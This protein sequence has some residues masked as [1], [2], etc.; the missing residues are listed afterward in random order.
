MSTDNAA[1]NAAAKAKSDTAFLG[2]P[3]GL[4]W[5]S[6]SEFW[7][8]FSYYGMQS[9]LVLYLLN[10]LLKPG[11]IEQVWGFEAFHRMLQWLGRAI[12]WLFGNQTEMAV[13]SMTSQLYA[14][15]V[16]VTPLLGGVLADR[17]L[18]R[19]R[20]VAIGTLMMLFGT[21]LLALNQ[22]FLIG[23]A[24][25][26]AGVGC[27]K[28]NI[29]SQV[30]DLYRIDDKRRA[31]GFQ[32]YFMGI[33]LAVITAPLICGTLGQKVDWHLGFVASGVGMAL[34]LA[35]YLFGRR[36]FPPE[37]IRQTGKAEKAP[38][39]TLRDWGVVILLVA[40]LPFLALSIIG[41]QEIF[42]AYLVWAE[43][44]YQLTA[45]GWTVPVSWMVSFD[46]VI[47][48]VTMIGVIAFWR[49]YGKRRREPDEITKIV[50]GVL[51]SMLAPLALAGASAVVA[52]TGHP[53][54]I[55]WALAFHVT[56][57][58]GFA[59]VLPVGL[60]LYS[61]AA[62]KGLGGTMIAIYYLHLFFANFV[63][64][65]PL[66]GLLGSMP[67]TKFWLLHAG[68]MAAAAVVLLFAK[69]LFGRV[70]S[71]KAAPQTAQA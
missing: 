52:A 21:F 13:A 25:L 2:H 32:I 6:A 58:I 24:F 33:Q 54:N 20:T 15:L 63:L 56:N 59:N 29:A 23:L 49:W 57:D 9:I 1:A 45:F 62:P 3:K 43:K 40:L 14:G 67:D 16:Y 51:I 10:Y 50:I 60:A 39:L 19:T 69:L 36:H 18:G 48:S 64:V 55:G 68:L 71:P 66:G 22:T 35:I 8:R 61:R 17:F 37:P 11:H 70:L 4:G 42:N 31:D 46:A 44:N 41:N 27:F 38:P 65:G 47:S 12:P 53:V 26:L 30:G 5:L 28:G 7:E 34:A